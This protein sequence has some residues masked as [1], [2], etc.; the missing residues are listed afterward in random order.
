LADESTGS[1]DHETERQL[2]SL[3]ARLQQ[4]NGFAVLWMTHQFGV[5]L[6]F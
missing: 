5:K 3:I 2:L 6:S 4:E 1:L